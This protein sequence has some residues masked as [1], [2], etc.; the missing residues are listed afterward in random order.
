MNGPF[1]FPSPSEARVSA[2]A[3]W[4]GE[5]FSVGAKSCRVLSYGVGRSGWDENLTRLHEQSAG[6]DH[7]MDD[8]SRR[9]TIE[10]VERSITRTPATIIE[11]GCSSGFLLRQLVERLPE[12]IIIGSDYTL[13]TLQTLAP[14]VPRVPLLHFD[15]TRCP[16]PDGSAD[17]AILLNVLE[18][19][20]DDATALG[21]VFRVLRPGGTAVIEVPAQSSLLD[22]YD[23]VLMHFRRYD[24]PRLIELLRQTGFMIERRS[25]LGFFLFP[26]FYL[27]KRLN[28]MRYRAHRDIDEQAL[29]TRMIINTAR[30]GPLMR[31]LMAAEHWLRRRIYLPFG[32]RCLITCRKPAR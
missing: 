22:V 32:I 5:T 12:H 29:V 10:E 28:Q 19:I 4:N 7:F 6:K 2:S 14:E 21:Q 30:S 13:G 23:R 18:H 8:A 27:S 17:I 20:E 9:H 11:F 16:L 1:T 26:P 24:M 15:L 31:H 25:H 3:I